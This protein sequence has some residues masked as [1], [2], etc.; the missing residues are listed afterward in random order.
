MLSLC[1]NIEFLVLPLI[2][3]RARDLSGIIVF[4]ALPREHSLKQKMPRCQAKPK[5]PIS[6]RT[7]VTIVMIIKSRALS[8]GYS[9]L[10]SRH[11]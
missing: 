8:A 5:V 1:M 3:L 11:M 2:L 10:G 9:A 6:K 7:K 4:D